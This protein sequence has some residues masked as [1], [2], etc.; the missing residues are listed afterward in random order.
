MQITK[1]LATAATKL[2][3][4]LKS[5]SWRK[6]WRTSS[7]LTKILLVIA[8]LMVLILGSMYSISLWFKLKHQNQPMQWGTSWSFKYARELG[9]NPYE[10]LQAVVEGLPVQRIR[11]MSYWDIHEPVKDQF[12]WHELDWQFQLIEDHNQQVAACRQLRQDCRQPIV[13]SL[14]VGLRQPRWPEC[15]WPNWAQEL[16]SQ[17]WQQELTDYISAV[18]ERYDQQQNLVE[19]QL[20]NEFF[21]KAFGICPDHSRQRLIDE[22]NHLNSLTDKRITISRSNNAL[23]WPLYQPTPDDYSVSVYKRVYDQNLTNHYFEYPFPAWFYGFLAGISEITQ[24]KQNFF[25]HE[26]Q[27]EPWGPVPTKQLS[28]AEQM[29]S[30][31]A[32]RLKA[33][34]EYG[35]NTGIRTIDIWGAEWYYWQFTEFNNPNPWLTIQ[36]QLPRL[37]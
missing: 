8:G 32:N 20:E 10:G 4:R 24:G 16:P 21:L 3:R 25:I 2:G 9:V 28:Q 11:L 14:A 23:G 7:L 13:I 30:M 5:A 36:R 22:Y 15:H 27:A 19:Y 37:D 12:D 35:H 1:Q 26:L 6:A 17:S 33:R 29:K 31:D 18:V 34:L